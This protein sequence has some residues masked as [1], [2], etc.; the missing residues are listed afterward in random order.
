ME[1]A[2]IHIETAMRALNIVKKNIGNQG[3]FRELRIDDL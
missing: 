1:G 2:N 3:I